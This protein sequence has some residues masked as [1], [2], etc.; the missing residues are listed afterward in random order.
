MQ[1]QTVGAT[2]VVALQ[3]GPCGDA[4]A[5]YIRSR[6]KSGSGIARTSSITQRHH[7]GT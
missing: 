5:P 3:P 2:P 1:C 4:L 7:Q 6:L